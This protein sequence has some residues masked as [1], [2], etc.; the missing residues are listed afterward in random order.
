MKKSLQ[1]VFIL[2]GL[3]VVVVLLFSTILDDRFSPFG[4]GSPANTPP[5]FEIVGANPQFPPECGEETLDVGSDGGYSRMVDL[6]AHAVRSS[7]IVEGT[8]RVSGAARFSGLEYLSQ[9]RMEEASGINTPFTI[10]VTKTHKGPE[11]EQWAVSERGGQVGCV[12]F[13]MSADALRLFDGATG[14]F[15]IS[16]SS[17]FEGDWVSMA[18]VE[19]APDW[20]TFSDDNF[21]S[22]E[23]AVDLIKSYN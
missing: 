22:I 8:A 20:F 19:N 15:F 7:A 21:G 16:G 1:M 23:E 9:T 13:Q 10:Q 6:K 17:E 12:N 5:S 4:K 14:L 11:Q 3:G 2:A 18:I